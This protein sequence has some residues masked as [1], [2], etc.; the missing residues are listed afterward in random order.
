MDYL[1]GATT[2]E[3]QFVSVERVADYTRLPEEVHVEEKEKA[4]VPVL[5]ERN[6]WPSSGAIS[7]RGVHLRYA[8]HLFPALRGV[9]I[10]IPAGA[11]VAL[12]GRTGCG[13]SSLLGVMM[14]LYRVNEG[15]IV[16]DGHDVT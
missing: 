15:E 14:R 5:K 2:L 9:D 1:M 3:T 10:E 8:P 4:I 13:K 11:K 7:V 16:I 6:C 12:C